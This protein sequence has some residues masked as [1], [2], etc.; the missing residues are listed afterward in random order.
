MLQS[1]VDTYIC[2]LFVSGVD[3]MKFAYIDTDF[4]FVQ[5]VLY[6]FFKILYFSLTTLHKFYL[7]DQFDDI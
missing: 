7:L 1:I 4:L 6:L 3:K 2:K 5:Y